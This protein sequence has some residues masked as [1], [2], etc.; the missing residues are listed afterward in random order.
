MTSP[1]SSSNNFKN[2]SV[3]F[4]ELG[5]KASKDRRKV[6]LAF[7]QKRGWHDIRLNRFQRF[8]RILFGAYKSSHLEFV[9]KKLA[10]PA[11]ASPE[12]LKRRIN[13]LWVKTYPLAK[14]PLS[15]PG[16]SR[17]KSE[18]KSAGAERPPSFIGIGNK[19]DIQDLIKEYGVKE[20]GPA[21]KESNEEKQGAKEEKATT[22]D[23]IVKGLEKIKD[24]YDYYPIAGDGHCM[25]RSIAAGI[26]LE[27]QARPEKLKELRTQIEEVFKELP[28]EN[29]KGLK[30]EWGKILDEQEK[31]NGD[32][33]SIMNDELKSQQAVSFLRSLAVEYGK[34]K[35]MSNF[36]PGD[37]KEYW[38]KMKEMNLNEPELGGHPELAA[39]SEALHL[40]FDIV[41]ALAHGKEESTP[42]IEVK[43]PILSISLLYRSDGGDSGHY[44]LAKRRGYA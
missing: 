33:S 39:L 15:Q 20:K 34:V 25:F 32:F 35:G 5:K 16:Q 23:F 11:L 3:P 4:E 28:D 1:P 19:G 27:L 29:L 24:D 41:D 40:S 44:D 13:S 36:I 22:S 8:L 2:V 7:N 14:S 6:Y 42:L 43:N 17:Q 37:P 38:G 31:P 12:N 30:E 18:I 9:A 10:D 21:E 26:F